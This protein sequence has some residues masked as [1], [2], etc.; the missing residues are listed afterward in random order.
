MDSI[1]QQLGAYV[2]ALDGAGITAAAQHAA[3]VRVIDSLACAIG[4]Y[5]GEPCRIA[6]TLA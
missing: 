3:T 1:T 4:G 6:R 2:A 5:H